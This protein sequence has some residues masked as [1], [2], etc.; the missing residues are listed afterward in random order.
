MTSK[1]SRFWAP[2]DVSTAKMAARI[3]DGS[4]VMGYICQLF[5][6]SHCIQPSTHLILTNLHR[7]KSS[8]H[9]GPV[10]FIQQYNICAQLGS[11]ICTEACPYKGWSTTSLHPHSR[12]SLD[13]H[14]SLWQAYDSHYCKRRNHHRIHTCWIPWRACC[15][16]LPRPYIFQST[17][18]QICAQVSYQFLLI[19]TSQFR[20][21][22]F[23]RQY[24]IAS[25]IDML[26][27]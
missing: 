2:R 11:G 3:K 26:F 9:F 8:H 1:D 7:A 17:I 14:Q 24:K 19:F 25:G 15:W 22:S 6:D 23:R 13:T 16:G 4:G 27:T 20:I 5:K 18:R 21:S 12:S 10:S